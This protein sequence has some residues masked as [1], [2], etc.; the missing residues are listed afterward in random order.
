ML[1]GTWA[2]FWAVLAPGALGPAPPSQLVSPPAALSPLAAAAP[3]DDRDSAPTLSL[4]DCLAYAMAHQPALAAEQARLA[5]GQA[6][7]AQAKAPRAV[8]LNGSAA[9]VWWDKLS[10]QTARL[11]GTS[12][13]DTSVGLSMSYRLYSGGRWVW[14]ER[15][16]TLG[17]SAEG[18]Q[19]ERVAQQTLS[20]VTRAFGDLWLAEQ[21]VRAREA[22]V[23]QTEAHR[24]LAQQRAALGKVAQV[25]TLR[26]EV[27]VATARDAARRAG[28]SRRTAQLRLNEALGRTTGAPL[29]PPEMLPQLAPPTIPATEV[30]RQ[31]PEWQR[32]STLVSQTAA[33]VEAAKA[34]RGPEVFAQANATAI[35]LTDFS[36]GNNWSA[37]LEVRLPI[38]DG[39][40][41]K[42]LVD[43]A[44]A[45]HALAVAQVES[46]RQ[47]IVA[48]ASEAQS[49]MADAMARRAD[50]S[51]TQALAEQ[52]LSITEERYRVGSAM[53]LEVIDAQ[54]ALLDV[55]L[56]IY[57]A[58]VDVYQATVRLGLALGQRLAP[59]T[60]GEN[61]GE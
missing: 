29:P 58:E 60:S 35:G 32:L 23:R 56:A 3:A 22:L 50:L 45:S 21:V 19:A 49:A 53:P 11:A 7:V 41:L 6:L 24:D 4:A 52:A 25:E 27:S 12:H 48:E 57:A 9:A 1:V 34:D 47:S 31:H 44:R 17:L 61:L 2:A 59:E 37:G 55:R 16:A 28:Q 40:R 51:A 26:A 46:L 14:R 18:H 13:L 39:G 42:A 8:A 38:L 20:A 10:Q 30:W 5:Q 15:A 54:T 33:Q 43:Q 36:P